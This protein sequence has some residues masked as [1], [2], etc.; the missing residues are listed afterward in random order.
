MGNNALIE[1]GWILAGRLEPEDRAAVEKAHK[2]LLEYLRRTLPEFDWKMPVVERREF[3]R[4]TRVEPMVLLDLAVRIAALSS[5]W[6]SPD[7][8]ELVDS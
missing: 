7:Y 8:D 2:R 1:M 6:L 3:T 5:F 4:R